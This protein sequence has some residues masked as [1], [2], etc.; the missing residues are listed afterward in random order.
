VAKGLTP[1]AAYFG[2]VKTWDDD[3][4]SHRNAGRQHVSILDDHDHVSGDKVRFS[5]DAASDH[6]VVA[7]VAIQLFSLGIPCIYYGTEQAFAGPEKPERDRFLPDYNVGN[8]PPDKYLR[9]AMFGPSHPRKPGVDGIGA[10]GTVI[11]STLPGF[12]PFGTVGAHAFDAGASAFVRIAA[13]VRARQR[14]PVLRYGRMYPRPVSL[15]GEPF[16]PPA[17]GELIAWSRVLDDEE[18]LCVVNGHGTAARGGDVLVDADL[19][20]PGAAGQ[21]FGSS[22]PFFEV[23][24]NSAQAAHESR[25]G[26]GPYAG[27]HPVGERVPV[28]DRNGAAF[29]AIRQLPPSETIVLI[30]RP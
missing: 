6:Q 22:G 13:L 11:D 25:P 8:P 4:G 7:G 23:I 28:F 17:A 26:A 27:P 12:G 15:F 14:L 29:V 19:N 5:S 21:P 20:S 30:N 3:L 24:A 1:P 10:S 2:Y 16:G 9:E 18:A